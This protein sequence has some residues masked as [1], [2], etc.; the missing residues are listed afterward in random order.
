MKAC[1]QG[2]F[3]DTCKYLEIN[4]TYQDFDIIDSSGTT[5]QSSENDVWDINGG[6]SLYRDTK[7]KN[8]QAAIKDLKQKCKLNQRS[9]STDRKDEK[10]EP[11]M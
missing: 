7:S 9:N 8:H 3:Q 10:P 2:W 5:N 1:H 4:K 11:G 6:F